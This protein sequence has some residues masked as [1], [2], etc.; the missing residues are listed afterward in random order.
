MEVGP[1]HYFHVV[2]TG[3]PLSRSWGLPPSVSGLKVVAGS[4]RYQGS[5]AC[6]AVV[7]RRILQQ[8]A[9]AGGHRML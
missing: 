5:Q 1:D 3:Q 6:R 8:K 2:P 7:A 9:C 4:W